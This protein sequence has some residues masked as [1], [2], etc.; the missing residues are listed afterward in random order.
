MKIVLLLILPLI[1][2]LLAGCAVFNCS[3]CKVRRAG[4]LSYGG[5][6]AVR[7]ELPGT[8]DLSATAFLDRSVDGLQVTVEV[9]DDHLLADPAK[10][11][12]SSDSV[13]F[14]AD[15]RPYR[16]RV[17]YNQYA[18]GV[19]QMIVR[20]AIG[21]VPL[22]WHLKSYGFPVPEGIRVASLETSTGYIVQFFLP[23]ESFREIH[24]PFRDPLYLD[25]AVNDVDPA[26]T[27]GKFFWKGNGDDWQHPHN[28]QPVS[29]PVIAPK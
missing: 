7:L 10:D 1:L 21:A 20:P 18:R 6:G 19:F 23:E 25:I 15:L 8:A 14:Y 2:A 26:G 24:G 17:L 22:E 3:A 9:Q 4:I 12:W 28:F 11:I 16:E 29:L 27:Q 5:E 13:E